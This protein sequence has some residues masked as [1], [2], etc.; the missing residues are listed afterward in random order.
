M[1]DLIKKNVDLWPILVSG[2]GV[3]ELL[4]VAKISSA[5]REAKLATFIE[6]FLNCEIA[7]DI[8]T[9]CFETTSSNTNYNSSACIL[10]E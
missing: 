1:N 6:G 8:R 3:S 5:T 9:I 10:L 7:D 2:K 4:I